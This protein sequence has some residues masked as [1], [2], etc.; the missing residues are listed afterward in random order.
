LPPWLGSD[1][2]KY[3]EAMVRYCQVS[4]ER[5]GAPP[6]VVGIQ[7]EVDQSASM[8]HKMTLALR[9][10]L[11]EADFKSVKIHMSDSGTVTGGIKRAEKFRSSE[12]VWATIDYSATHMYDYQG[13]FTDP[14]GFDARLAQ[15]KQLTAD[16][17]FLST[18]LCVND[19][20]FQW[21][22]YRVALT[23]GQLYHKNLVLTDAVA[24]CY[25]WTLLN[26]VQPSYGWTRSLCVPEREH[27]FVPVASSHQLRVF[28]A[29][30]RRIREGMIRVETQSSNSDLLAC[31]F[32]AR[33]NNGT[34]VLLNRSSRPQRV[35]VQWPG[36]RF[37]EMELVDPYHENEVRR[38]PMR[39]S[40]RTVEVDVGP[41]AVVTLS[42]VPLG[43]LAPHVTD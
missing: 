35:T 31:A 23:M 38:V 22:T 29:Y 30:S 28:G 20:R 40:K 4:K 26:V 16:K 32:R 8:F 15:W 39:Q 43:R 3:A 42:N 12:T 41:G 2:D 1:P 6:D 27:G 19:S 13:F 7:N 18:E 21:P 17:P 25:C 37:T 33:E 36:V 11:D 5:V 9:R 34:V 10:G 14:D 24:I